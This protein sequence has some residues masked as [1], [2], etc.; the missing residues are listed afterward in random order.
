MY[1]VCIGHFGWQNL[2]MFQARELQAPV[3]REDKRMSNITAGTLR[4]IVVIL[5]SIWR[6]FVES[7]SIRH[8]VSAGI[9]ISLLQYKNKL[10]VL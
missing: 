7:T 1:C 8:L 2:E 9:R 5:T 6:H 3:V 10:S 4:Q